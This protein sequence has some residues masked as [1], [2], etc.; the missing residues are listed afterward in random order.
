[1]AAADFA[2]SITAL[3]GGEVLAW[4]LSGHLKTEMIQHLQE[5]VPANTIDASF[6]DWFEKRLGACI[7][8]VTGIP[9]LYLTLIALRGVP[10]I[11][12]WSETWIGYAVAIIGTLAILA[13]GW[14]KSPPKMMSKKFLGLS[15]PVLS[16][17]VLN[18]VGIAVLNF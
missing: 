15:I 10:R 18:L 3:L 14:S 9:T 16:L 12:E 1:M 7:T 8:A 4:R 2:A 11:A 17:L 13:Y 6:P 5:R